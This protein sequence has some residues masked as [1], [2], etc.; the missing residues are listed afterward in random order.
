MQYSNIMG[1]EV[2]W[3]EHDTHRCIPIA[4]EIY[5]TLNRYSDKSLRT[6]LEI[7]VN[8]FT[9]PIKSSNLGH[10][11]RILRLILT[12]P[13]MAL[14][15]TWKEFI[16]WTEEEMKKNPLQSLSICIPLDPGLK[17]GNNFAL[18][19]KK[20]DD[21]KKSIV[22]LCIVQSCRILEGRFNQ[23]SELDSGISPLKIFISHT[24]RDKQGEYISEEIERSLR[25]SRFD[26]FFDKRDIQL[27]DNLTKKL[28]DNVEDAVLLVIRT[29]SLMTSPWCRQEIV[30]ARE[31][32][33][34]IILV[35]AMTNFDERSSSLFNFLPVIRINPQNIDED[36]ISRVEDFINLEVLRF[37]YSKRK[38]EF[39]K[40][41]QFVDNN[42][43]LLVRPPEVSDMVQ[44]K[45]KGSYL[46]YPD[47]VISSEESAGLEQFGVKSVTPITMW[48][49]FLKDHSVG[50]SSDKVD[51]IGLSSFHI[52]DATRI[53]SRALL[54]SG[55]NLVYSGIP[56]I[57]ESTAEHENLLIFLFEM[58]KSYNR[59]G[60]TEFLPL[61]NHTSWPF[62]KNISDHWRA[63][64]KEALDII[65]HD[66]PPEASQ[67]ENNSIDEILLDDFGR[68]LVGVS[69]SKMRNRIVKECEAR[70]VIGGS[71]NNFNGFYP[72]II[73]ESVIAF[74]KNQPLYILG[75]FG[76]AAKDVTRVLMGKSP[77]SFTTTWQKKK[78]FCF[79][80]LLETIEK[81]SQVNELK[82]RE[83]KK[84]LKDGGI[85][86]VSKN[87]GLSN[88][89]NL[90]IWETKNIEEA[91]QLIM[92]GLQNVF[93]PSDSSLKN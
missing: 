93:K 69:L 49:S 82:Y 48:G 23:K 44:A 30:A 71:T 88:E 9:N 84:T 29:E 51:E 73:E 3:H 76:G 20:M 66:P 74:R 90:R 6:G 39:L 63:K 92:L 31:N 15:P 42:A 45:K 55:A 37:F 47:P 11:S 83:M 70:I 26:T 35:D 86:A 21:S 12:T 56:S 24:K 54:A 52:T 2:Y 36:E 67:F 58:I 33:R 59:I 4:E 13:K 19:F 7:P 50:I 34:P 79:Q 18:E 81:H 28:R 65:E 57:S 14:E 10:A 53:I 40:S 89:Q 17:I 78:T 46:L 43:L 60:T 41:N 62:W 16:N 85:D 32:D 22:S 77:K 72:S 64:N 75:G 5:T 68:L 25:D 27:G 38:L 87:N 1:I 80:K 91:V 61:Q 8:F